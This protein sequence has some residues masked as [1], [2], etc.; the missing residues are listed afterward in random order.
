MLRT[1]VSWAELCACEL[2]LAMTHDDYFSLA[3][4]ISRGGA[5]Y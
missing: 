1:K 5:T 2:T 4:C 3:A